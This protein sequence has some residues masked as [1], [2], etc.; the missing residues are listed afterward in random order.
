[1]T[2]IDRRILGGV[3]AA[4][5]IVVSQAWLR[6][7]PGAA[8]RWASGRASR[9][10]PSARSTPRVDSIARAVAGAA[11]RLPLQASCLEQGIALVL[12]LAIARHPARLVVGVSR[13]ES[14]IR[15][16]AWV[17]SEGRVILGSASEPEFVALPLSGAC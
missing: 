1:V 8:V 5:A 11:A 14:S 13:E 4:C 9:H 2:A 3:A 17:E 15:A 16:H 10:Q 6:V 12:L 7:A